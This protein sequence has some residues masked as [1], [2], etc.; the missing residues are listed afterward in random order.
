MPASSTQSKSKKSNFSNDNSETSLDDIQSTNVNI[1]IYPNPSKGKFEISVVNSDF[2][3][4]YFITNL[5]GVKVNRDCLISNN[6]II[7]ISALS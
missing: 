1:S 5:N 3:V 6:Q 2:P 7:D 4:N